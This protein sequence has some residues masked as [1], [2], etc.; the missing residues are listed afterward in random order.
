MTLKGHRVTVVAC[1]FSL[2]GRRIVSASHDNTLKV[3]DAETGRCEATLEGHGGRV[4][5]CAFSPD[6]QR[7]VSASED[8]ALKLWGTDTAFELFGMP[9]LYSVQC[10]AV[11]PAFPRLVF[12]DSGGIVSPVDMHGLGWGGAEGAALRPIRA[13]TPP[14]RTVTRPVPPDVTAQDERRGWHRVLPFG[15]R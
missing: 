3:W 9:T 2:D 5:A 8:R 14:D 6:G 15:H 10:V 11:H 7:I 12:G 4:N 1:A 13:T